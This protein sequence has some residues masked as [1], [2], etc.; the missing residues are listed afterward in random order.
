MGEDLGLAILQQ[1]AAEMRG[2]GKQSLPKVQL[3]VG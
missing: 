3:R 1:T 2:E